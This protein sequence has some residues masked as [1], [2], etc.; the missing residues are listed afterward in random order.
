MERAASLYKQGLAPYLLPSGGFKPHVGTT[1]WNYLKNIGIK[2]GVP[3]EAIL[4]E[5]KA[6]H[7][8]EN[9][10]FSMEVLKKWGV[11][12]K[13]VIIV[14]KAGHSQR[15]LLSYKAEFSKEAGFLSPL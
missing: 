13:K 15:A 8:L 2:N 1:E 9:S 14:C 10:R 7:T 6:Q 11:H 3:D 12:P 5:D 4:K